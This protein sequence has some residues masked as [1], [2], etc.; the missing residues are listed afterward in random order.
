MGLMCLPKLCK[1]HIDVCWARTKAGLTCLMKRRVE[2]KEERSTFKG[3]K[4][5]ERKKAYIVRQEL[6]LWRQR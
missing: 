5:N 1:Y 2:R 4:E 6:V 3:K